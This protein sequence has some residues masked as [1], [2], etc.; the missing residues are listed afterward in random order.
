MTGA[1]VRTGKIQLGILGHV[2]GSGRGSHKWHNYT[3][4]VLEIAD[5]AFERQATFSNRA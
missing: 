3:L 1:F 5:P 2:L 4:Y